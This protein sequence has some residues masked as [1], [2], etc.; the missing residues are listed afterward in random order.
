[1]YFA[2]NVK[3][4][5]P[6]EGVDEAL[7]WLDRVD[8]EE[9]LLGKGISTIDLRVRDRVV[10]VPQGTVEPAGAGKVKVSE[11]REQ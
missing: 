1:L 4:A 6:E 10:I 9:G 2:N 5:L 3:V 7:A 11:S 8:A